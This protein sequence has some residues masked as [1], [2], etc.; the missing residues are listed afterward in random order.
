[1]ILVIYL[2]IGCQLSP[3][4]NK[5]EENEL[6]ETLN[7][8]FDEVPFN[9][10]SSIRKENYHPK[11]INPTGILLEGYCGLIYV[12]NL[13]KK[14]S[15]SIFA[16]INENSKINFFLKDT[17]KYYIPSYK[18]SIVENKAPII[19]VNNSKFTYPVDFDLN[20]TE[21]F[22]FNYQSGNYFT[23]KGLKKLS[24]L[25]K[26]EEKKFQGKGYSNGAIISYKSM[27]VVYWTIIW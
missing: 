7:T 3:D 16:T 1:M 12:Y 20:S 9:S 13:D 14:K 25:P 2:L 21:V 10:I 18:D 26:I 6:I 4:N 22:V 11:I 24:N 17:A 27:I 19:N 8:Y 15:D 23:E 5:I